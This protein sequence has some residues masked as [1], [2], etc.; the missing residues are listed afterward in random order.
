MK[1][2]I[3]YSLLAIIVAAIAIVG[4]LPKDHN[5]YTGPTVI[6]FKNHTRG[7][8]T[9]SLCI[10]GVYVCTAQTDSTR[11]VLQ[12]AVNFKATA[13]TTNVLACATVGSTTYQVP[14]NPTLGA[15]AR[16]TDSILVQLV[17]P[18]RS[19]PTVVNY[20]VRPVSGTITAVEGT[21]YSF[22]PAG[23][24]TVTIPANSSSAWILINIPAT[25]DASGTSKTLAIDLLGASDAGASP[26]Y[27]K[28]ILT[29]RKN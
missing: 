6:E 19:T 26:N 16:G 21:N 24:R 15:N 8:T 25:S 12:N 13:A 29:I 27:A 2:S 1:K 18:Q 14:S 4:C 10:L 5:T 22:I 17:G 11:T 20:S 3:I 9:Q 28:F 7:V 23:A